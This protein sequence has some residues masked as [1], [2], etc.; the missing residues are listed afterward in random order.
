MNLEDV[1]TTLDGQMEPREQQV[2]DSAKIIDNEGSVV[3][4]RPVGTGKTE[5][6]IQA[7]LGNA[8]STDGRY[9]SLILGP[10]NSVVSQWENRLEKYNLDEIFDIK[11]NKKKSEFSQFQNVRNVPSQ[12]GGKRRDMANVEDRELKKHKEKVFGPENVP[13]S[14]SDKVWGAHSINTN[15]ADIILST[16]QLLDSDIQNNRVDVGNVGFDDIVIDEA[17]CSVARE[18]LQDLDSDETFFGGYKPAKRFEDLL[19]STMDNSN[20]IAL[21]ALPGRKLDA[22]RDYLGA[23]LI[24]PQKSNLDASMANV[25][26]L[27]HR[28]DENTI[29]ENVFGNEVGVVSHGLNQ[30]EDSLRTSKDELKGEI[31]AEKGQLASLSRSVSPYTYANSN[32]ENLRNA[33]VKALSFEQRAQMIHEGGLSL[34]EG[35]IEVDLPHDYTDPKIEGLDNLSAA[36]EQKGDNYIVFTTHKETAEYLNE[37]VGRSTT[38]VDGDRSE[39]HNDNALEG[40]GDE[41]NGIFMTYGYGS[42]GIDLPQGDRIVHMTDNLDPELKHSATGRAK[43]GQDIKEHTLL[44]KFEDQNNYD[45]RDFVEDDGLSS[46]PETRA[47]LRYMMDLETPWEEIIRE[48][49]FRENEREYDHILNTV[50]RGRS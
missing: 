7:M 50:P 25:Q 20:Y 43:R 48:E 32:N 8:L 34:I 45:S 15:G 5:V 40:F 14:N 31:K 37:L 44:Y 2:E 19:N 17:T 41:F 49:Q 47:R 28:F 11:R 1:R 3:V 24:R 46:H 6:A 35:E 13:F 10:S 16:Y 29:T 21:T 39:S 36:W 9:R 22:I 42:E 33:A 27:E 4:Q 38:V 12:M 26:E 23:S 18:D 30:V